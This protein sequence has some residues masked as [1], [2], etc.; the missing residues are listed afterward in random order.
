MAIAPSTP[1][2][3]WK[4]A[5]FKVI[6]K[7]MRI[8]VFKDRFRRYPLSPRVTHSRYYPKPVN[9]LGL[10]WMD[11]PLGPDF[12]WRSKSCRETVI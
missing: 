2:I 1:G 10:P 11:L 5:K 3:N 7:K 8:T 4:M 12:R 6:T 9:I